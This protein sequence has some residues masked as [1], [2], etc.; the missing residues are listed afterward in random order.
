ME[1][2]QRET[3][4]CGRKMAWCA[5]NPLVT[6]RRLIKAYLTYGE[7]NKELWNCSSPLD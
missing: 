7:I 6:I 3:R 5:E 4:R 1:A 2:D